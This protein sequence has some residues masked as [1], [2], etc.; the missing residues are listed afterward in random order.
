MTVTFVTAFYSSPNLS[1]RSPDIYFKLFENLLESGIPILLFLD[2]KERERGE[3]MKY[4]NLTI[5][6]TTL[7]RDWI[8]QSNELILPSSR[9]INKEDT[10][11]YFYIQLSK[12]ANLARASTMVQTT[13]LAW[14]DFGIFHMFSNSEKAKELLKQIEQT[15][16]PVDKVFS[17][18][19]MPYLKDK[20]YI[21]DVVTWYHCGSFMIGGK[22]LFSY[23]YQKQT[24]LVLQYLPTITWEVNY[25]S[26]MDGF[27]FY[28]ADHNESLLTGFLSYLTDGCYGKDK[29]KAAVHD[30][31][32]S[33]TAKILLEN[34]HH[35]E[36]IYQIV[37]GKWE[38]GWGSYLFD[39]CSYSYQRATLKKQEALFN[40][41]KRSTLVLEIG[42]YLGH[43][44]FI[45]LVSNPNL[46]ITC[47]D[48]DVRFAPKVV[49]YLNSVFDNRITFY[50]GNAI[51][52]L[53]TLTESFDTIHIDADHTIDA[54][55]SQFQLSIPHAMP[56]AFI[57]FDDYE[58]VRPIIDE[59][60]TKNVLTHITTPWCL[61]TNIVTR[62]V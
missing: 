18:G 16:I 29:L 9:N 50:L 27:T 26:M 7:D 35:F 19:C 44:L 1:F 40:V 20:K 51:D 39:G 5:E 24:E 25:W 61:W 36:E 28:K 21:N 60:I 17:P 62:L 45:L 59:W 23:L 48:N 55:R 53:P 56:N 6:Y 34:F 57:V 47:I 15:Y 52:I 42:V 41:G 30:H 3:K 37:G 49:S 2:E 46:R 33:E 11:D 8:P 12:L 22:S 43:S 4:Q 31:P 10:I 54:V 58:A 38:N 14:I 32:E 13:H